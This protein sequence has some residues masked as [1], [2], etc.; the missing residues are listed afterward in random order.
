MLEN[1]YYFCKVAKYGSITKAAEDIHISQ[2]ALSAAISRLEKQLDAKLFERESKG[3]ILTKTGKAVLP[4]IETIC[5]NYDA[6]QREITTSKQKPNAIKV[7]GA[8]QHVTQIISSFNSKYNSIDLHYRQYFDYYE[9][10]HALLNGIVDVVL[11]A[12]PIAGK[13]IKTVVLK[14]EPLGI[15]ISTSN[16]L[17]GCD[18]VTLEDIKGQC[19]V[20]QPPNA[21][22]S[23]A[24]AKCMEQLGI[25][26]KFQI[27]AENNAI[28]DMLRG[29]N[30]QNYLAVYPEYRGREIMREYPVIKWIP[31]M[32]EGLTREIAISWL[33]TSDKSRQVKEF[34]AFCKSF[35]DTDYL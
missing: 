4:F 31:I 2:P 17:A 33:E 30:S 34:I 16:Y 10:K 3:V 32:A 15:L 22:I 11:S 29:D 14:S 5:D 20:G 23:V 21:P 19:L 35:Y 27:E 24:I 1:F 28:Y 18:T 25:Y 8:M 13:Q 7:G 6:L 12:P 9:L 26:L